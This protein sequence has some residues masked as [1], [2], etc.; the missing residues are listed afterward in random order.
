MALAYLRGGRITQAIEAL[1]KVVHTEEK[2]LAADHHDRLASQHAH[3]QAIKLF[4][5]ILRERGIRRVRGR[6][7]GVTGVDFCSC[8]VDSCC[9][10]GCWDA[11]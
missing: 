2:K 9:V 11:D 4:K 7:P 5:H 6:V 1:E 3:F 10:G 8:C